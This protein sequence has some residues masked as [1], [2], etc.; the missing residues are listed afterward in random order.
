MHWNNTEGHPLGGERN[1]SNDSDEE[2]KMPKAARD[3][4]EIHYKEKPN[5]P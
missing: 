1:D 5:E 2:S 4:N 3:P